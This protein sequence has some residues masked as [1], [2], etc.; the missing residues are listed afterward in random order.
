MP[1]ITP[2]TADNRTAA[3]VPVSGSTIPNTLRVTAADQSDSKHRNAPRRGSTTNR[4]SVTLL[5]SASSRAKRSSLG[6]VVAVMAMNVSPIQIDAASVLKVHDSPTRPNTTKSNPQM[7]DEVK[8]PPSGL[9]AI[10]ISPSDLPQDFQAESNLRARTA[11]TVANGPPTLR[12]AGNATTGRV[13]RDLPVAPALLIRRVVA[14]R[15]TF[16][17]SRQGSIIGICRT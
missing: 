11:S 5:R 2:R 14:Q 7:R 10:P 8:N 17:P 4:R 16:A 6:A 1:S 15:R 12:P 9:S 3:F 13:A